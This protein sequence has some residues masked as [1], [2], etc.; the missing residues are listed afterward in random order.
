M[1]LELVLG[2]Y[3]WI[4]PIALIILGIYILLKGLKKYDC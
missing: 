1:L 2:A 3:A 4:G